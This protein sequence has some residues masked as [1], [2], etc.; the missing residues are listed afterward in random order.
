MRDAWR[1]VVSAGLD[2]R[3]AA[4]AL[5]CESVSALDGVEVYGAS[6]PT[7]IELR[8]DAMEPLWECGLAPYLLAAALFLTSLDPKKALRSGGRPLPT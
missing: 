1:A 2:S 4:N 8:V 6:D 3:P 5:I 7:P